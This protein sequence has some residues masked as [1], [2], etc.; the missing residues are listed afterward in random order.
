VNKQYW[1]TNSSASAHAA[2][3]AASVVHD[4][5]YVEQTSYTVKQSEPATGSFTVYVTLKNV[6]HAT[7][8]GVQI[9]VRPFRGLRL[10]DED[11]GNSNLRTLPEDDPL[12]QYGEWVDFPDLKPD[13]SATQSVVFLNQGSASPVVPG[14]ENDVDG[15]PKLKLTPEIVFETK[16]AN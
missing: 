13:E 12:S 8:T 4:G 10:G 16:K 5:A 9:H 11:G 6:G 3:A 7:A 15:Q 1:F 14:G 2:A